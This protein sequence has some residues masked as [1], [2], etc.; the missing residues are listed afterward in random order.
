VIEVAFLFGLAGRDPAGPPAAGTVAAVR[1]DLVCA[2]AVEDFVRSTV[3]T[4]RAPEP[5]RTLIFHLG[6]E[7]YTCREL[8]G[9]KLRAAAAADRRWLFWGRSEPDP[10]I[11]LRCNNL[12]RDLSRCPECGGSGI[13]R[14]HRTAPGADPEGACLNCGQWAWSHFEQRR[15][16]GACGGEGFAWIKGAFDR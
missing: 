6:A 16:C 1:T 10:E 4:A 3:P 13:C 9:R 11:R 8:A 5:F 12:L 2:A 7:C 14:L 15:D